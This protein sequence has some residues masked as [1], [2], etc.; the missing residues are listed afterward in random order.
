MVHPSHIKSR[1]LADSVTY[2]LDV[3]IPR[4]A[5]DPNAFLAM[6][7]VSNHQNTHVG[8]PGVQFQRRT[9]FHSVFMEAISNKSASIWNTFQCHIPEPVMEDIIYSGIHLFQ[10]VHY[11]YTEFVAKEKPQYM[12]STHGM[13][14]DAV[15]DLSSLYTQAQQTRPV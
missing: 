5:T 8:G 1:V 7:D 13:T 2:Q 9:A 14:T 11:L 4:V 15:I 3:Q 6:F 12:H 10:G